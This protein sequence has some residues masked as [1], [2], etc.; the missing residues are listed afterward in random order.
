MCRSQ[1]VNEIVNKNSSSEEECN[2]KQNFDSYDKF[3]IMSVEDDL[4]SIVAIEQYINNRVLTKDQAEG[5]GGQQS[6]ND[7]SEKVEKIEV[8]RNPQ[9]HKK[10]LK[11]L[12]KSDNH[13]VNMTKDTGSPVSI[14]NWTSIKQILEGS[15]KSK[16]IAAEKLNL[17]AQFLDYN[18]RPILILGALKANLRSAG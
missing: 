18:K 8:R 3:E 17:S 10:A 15:P 11:A 1:Q 16:F 14:L 2:L 4:K 6:P 13:V 9:S 12:V 7:K 5:S